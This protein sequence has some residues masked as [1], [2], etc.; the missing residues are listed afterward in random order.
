MPEASET[1]TSTVMTLKW[2][3]STLLPQ[4]GKGG[5]GNSAVH[6]TFGTEDK[7][8]MPEGCPVEVVLSKTRRGMRPRDKGTKSRRKQRTWMASLRRMTPVSCRLCCCCCSRAAVC[9]GARPAHSPCTCSSQE[10]HKPHG[11]VNMGAA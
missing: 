8:G 4:E 10:P 6:Y 5:E 7:M 9:L 3:I 2:G 1:L 11:L